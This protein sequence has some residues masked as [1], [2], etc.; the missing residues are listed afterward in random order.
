MFVA[1]S[2]QNFLTSPTGETTVGTTQATGMTTLPENTS[3]IYLAGGCFWGVEAYMSGIDG[4]ID[5]VS[6]YANGNTETP[7]YEDVIFRNTGHAE[8]VKVSY[9]ISRILL[10]EILIYYFAIIDPT[11]LNKQGNDV[12]TQYRTGIYYTD[13]DDRPIIE[14]RIQDVQKS[15][16]QPVVVEVEPMKNFFPAEEY[17]QDYLVKNPGGYCHIDLSLA[18]VYVIRVSGYPKP[19]IDDIRAKLTDLQFAVTQQNATEPPFDNEYNDNFEDGIYVD[20]VTGEPLF[21][22]KDKFHSGTGWPS[23]T[24]PIASYIVTYHEDSTLGVTRTE[25]RSR[26]GDSHLG[27][28]FEDG[29][30]ESGGLRY[31]INSTA[32]RFIPL[33]DMADEGYEELVNWIS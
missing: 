11:S 23:F 2:C 12:G 22:S 32:L 21:S 7:S 25:V 14:Q 31:C 6:G 13:P 19:P 26:S 24:Q 28:V 10:E 27:H 15:Y 9:D 18:K 8:T 33:A 29:P 20:I 5:A 1:S 30:I 16:S 3:T 4:V 17:H